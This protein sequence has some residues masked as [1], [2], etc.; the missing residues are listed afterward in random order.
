MVEKKLKLYCKLCNVSLFFWVMENIILELT[1]IARYLM[2]EYE[3]N[4]I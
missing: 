3:N 4:N 1:N 2:A